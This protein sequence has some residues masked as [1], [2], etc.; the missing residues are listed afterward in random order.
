M[1]QLEETIKQYNA[2]I[3]I[4]SDIA[5]FFLDIDISY[6]EARNSLQPNHQLPLRLRQKTPNHSTRNL[7]ALRKHQTKHPTL[8]QITYQKAT[9]V[10]SFNQTKHQRKTVTLEKHPSYILGHLITLETLTL[11]DFMGVIVGKTVE[12]YRMA[13]EDEIRRWNGFTKGL[14]KEDREAFGPS[15]MPAEVTP[16]PQATPPNQYSLNP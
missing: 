2:K 15:W 8:Q 6:E 10:L 9:T 14:R 7:H 4:I 3:V 12:S 11:T 13:L 16:Q 5:G 1:E